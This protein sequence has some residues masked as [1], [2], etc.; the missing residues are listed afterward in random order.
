MQVPGSATT[1]TGPPACSLH[2]KVWAVQCGGGLHYSN[3]RPQACSCLQDTVHQTAEGLQGRHTSTVPQLAGQAPQR[4]LEPEVSP[5]WHCAANR[6]GGQR[7]FQALW[8][9]L[10]AR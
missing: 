7:A 1:W 5:A 2:G 4:A 10:P 3:H 9:Q 8:A 6:L